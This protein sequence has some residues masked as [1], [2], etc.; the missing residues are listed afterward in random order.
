[1][2]ACRILTPTLLDAPVPGLDRLAE[3]GG[4]TLNAPPLPAGSQLARTGAVLTALAV[5]VEAAVKN[6]DR[7]VLLGGDCCQPIAVMAGLTRAG[8]RPMLLWL[9]AHG[10]FNTPGTTPS[11]FIGGMPLAML[12]GRGDQ[13]LLRALSLTPIPERDVILCDAR[14]L[15]PGE[16]EALAGSQV[17]H[18]RSLAAILE[19]DLAGRPLHVHLDVDVMSVEDAP[20]VLYP[21]PGGP[22][23]AGLV[24]LGRRLSERSV[25]VSVSMTT[26]VFDRDA[27]G[28]T[29]EACFT[30]LEG[31]LAKE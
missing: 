2:P 12:V 31:L 17:R 14:D 29:G 4:W 22:R 5:R 28:R 27:D 11:G 26:W 15:D 13:A 24:E 1:M 10:D 20:A 21:V 19:E 6:G 8:V 16:R 7:P 23:V 30:A 25:P 18:V 9:D 3:T